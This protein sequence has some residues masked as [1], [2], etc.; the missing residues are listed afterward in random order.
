MEI[1]IIDPLHYAGWD[2]LLSAG[3]HADFFHSSPWA[4]VLQDSYGYK[5][6]YFTVIDDG[7]LMLS[8]PVMEINSYLTGKKGVSLPFTDCCR[9]IISEKLKNKDIQNHLLEHGQKEGWKYLEVRGEGMF[10]QEAKPSAWYYEH[11]LALSQDEQAIYTRFRDS[12]RRNIKKAQNAGVEVAI[13]DSLESVREFHRLNC[14]TRKMHGLPPQPF[15]FFKNMH[16]H[17]ISKKHG[18]VVTASYQGQAIA[19]SVYF[20]FNG[21]ALYKYGASDSKFLHCRPNYLVMWKAIQWYSQNNYKSISFG[22][23]DP[24][25]SGLRQFKTGF[26]AEEGLLNYYR[27]D[28]QKNDFV[29]VPS[30]VHGWHTEVFKK[31]PIPMLRVIGRFLYRHMG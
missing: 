25:H 1:A 16:K 2:E 15:L 7:N 29:G 23:T 31:T 10:G 30:S 24:E 22:R 14:L 6:L 5:P 17:I 21:R 9:P 3:E 13:S 18:L 19:S 26:G 20:H 8:I 11:I 27:Y 28:L 4:G 12:T